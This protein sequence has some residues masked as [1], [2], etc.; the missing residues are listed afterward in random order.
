MG[1]V[2]AAVCCIG[3]PAI[4]AV[5]EVSAP[6]QKLGTN[7]KMGAQPG[8]PIRLSSPDPGLGLPVGPEKC[9]TGQKV[10]PH[11]GMRAHRAIGRREG[12]RKS[13]LD[14]ERR[15]RLRGAMQC[16]GSVNTQQAEPVRPRLGAPPRHLW[17]AAAAD[18]S[19]PA[20]AAPA[21]CTPSCLTPPRAHTHKPTPPPPPLHRVRP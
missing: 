3:A 7:G 12:A 6:R 17:M 4:R 18:G 11:R 19:G 5:K 14:V 10:A 20:R 13:E 9:H 8:A 15:E 1:S 16:G 2:L 21:S